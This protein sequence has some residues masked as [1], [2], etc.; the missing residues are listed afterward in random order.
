MG[1][2]TVGGVK[3]KSFKSFKVKPF[4]GFNNFQGCYENILHFKDDVN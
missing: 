3:F 1:L 2:T 4:V